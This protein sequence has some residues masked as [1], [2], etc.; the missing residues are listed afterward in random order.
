MDAVYLSHLLHLNQTDT[1]SVEGDVVHKRWVVNDG[2][3]L[4][5]VVVVV[6]WESK[7][8]AHILGGR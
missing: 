7:R 3:D 4:D 2:L 6:D 8:S 5:D 1:C